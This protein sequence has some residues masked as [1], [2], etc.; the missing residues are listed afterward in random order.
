MEKKCLTGCFKLEKFANL[1]S[2]KWW[3]GHNVPAPES[4]LVSSEVNPET[5]ILAQVVNL[6]NE[7][8]ID[9][10]KGN[11]ETSFYHK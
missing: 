7:E 1:N 3:L 5:R 8:K 11:K 4:L 6:G 2:Y 10:K 9:R